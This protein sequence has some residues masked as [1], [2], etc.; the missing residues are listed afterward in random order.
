MKVVGSEG[1]VFGDVDDVELDLATWRMTSLIVRV[2]AEAVTSLGLEK[3]FWSRARLSVPVHQVAG[4]T[5]VVVLR[6]SLEEFAQLIA[7]A[8]ADKT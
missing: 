1:G 4:A 7:A 5:D 2:T 8:D 3:P 6:S